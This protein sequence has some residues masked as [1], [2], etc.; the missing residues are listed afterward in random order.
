MRPLAA[1][2]LLALPGCATSAA[3]LGASNVELTLE[4]AKP[5]RVVA[6]CLSQ[7][8]VG[9]NPMTEIADDHFVVIRQNLYQIPII[10]WDIIGTPTGS[11]LELRYSARIATGDDKAR[12]CL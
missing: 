9:T 11:R 8:L 6:A 10:R 12:A 5:A 2:L 1:L 7:S 3:G 4:S